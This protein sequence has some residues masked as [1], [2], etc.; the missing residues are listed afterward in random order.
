LTDTL[1]RNI[2]EA[3][4]AI[5]E[6]EDPFDTLSKMVVKIGAGSIQ[7]ARVVNNLVN[8]DET[9]RK[10]F[11]RDYRVWQEMTERR[12]PES[13]SPSNEYMNAPE[14]EFKRTKDIEKAAESLPKL[15]DKALAKA[16]D[17]PEKLKQAFA[18][19][20]RNSYQTMPGIKTNPIGFS[21]YYDFLSKTQGKEEAD[22]RVEDFLTTREINK[23]KNRMVP[24]L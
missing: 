19:L 2:G 12:D 15:I 3:T 17:D 22:K 20:K 23:V 8:S 24:S 21:E 4:S 11:Y 7:N 16:G 13:G 14:K 5:A 10:N 1:A 6:G 18:N 9:Q